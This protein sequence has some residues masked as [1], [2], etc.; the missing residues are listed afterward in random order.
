MLF[1]KSFRRPVWPPDSGGVSCWPPAGGQ[2]HGSR[3][4][5]GLPSF[6]V[7]RIERVINKVDATA[8]L[9]HV[10]RAQCLQGHLMSLSP[11][12]GGPGPGPRACPHTREFLLGALGPG[13]RLPGRLRLSTRYWC[14]RRPYPTSSTLRGPDQP[15]PGPGRRGARLGRPSIPATDIDSRRDG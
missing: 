11:R 9:R 3:Q 2:A 13:P 1:S 12:S 10:S 8:Q 15:R 7:V 5:V 14:Q 6:D 4:I